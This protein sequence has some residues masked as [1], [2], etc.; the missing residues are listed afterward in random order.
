MS[1]HNRERRKAGVERAK[2]IAAGKIKPTP[3]VRDTRKVIY[4]DTEAGPSR[5]R[6]TKH[7]PPWWITPKEPLTA[8]VSSL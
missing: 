6:E 8:T 4:K 1:K 3:R 5:H 2:L 7:N